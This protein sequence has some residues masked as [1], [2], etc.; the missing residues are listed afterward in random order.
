M[1]CFGFFFGVELPEM[2]WSPHAHVRVP[3]LVILPGVPGTSTTHT[4]VTISE[5]PHHPSGH[6][7]SSCLKSRSPGRIR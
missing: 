6:K 5:I 4:L 7:N 3:M 1:G 2:S